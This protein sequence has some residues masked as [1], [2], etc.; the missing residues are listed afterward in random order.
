MPARTLR[1]TAILVTKASVASGSSVK[2]MTAGAPRLLPLDTPAV[3]GPERVGPASAA[4]EPAATS[5]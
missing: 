3:A 4:P 1:T 5:A 2:L